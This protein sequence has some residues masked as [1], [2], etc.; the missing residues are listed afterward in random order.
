M[1]AHP[2]PK[3]WE[4]IPQKPHSSNLSSPSQ[5]FLAA[6]GH[7]DRLSDV[8]QVGRLKESCHWISVPS[9]SDLALILECEQSNPEFH[10]S[11]K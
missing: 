2:T 4:D 6:L 11:Q 3:C 1:A 9:G 5:L 8:F 7:T 10:V